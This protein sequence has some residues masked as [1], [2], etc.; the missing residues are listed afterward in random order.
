M[1]TSFQPLLKFLCFHLLALMLS[2]TLSAAEPPKHLSLALDGR[3][4]NDGKQVEFSW[5]KARGS[6]VGRISIQRRVLGQS[7]KQSWKDHASVRGFA[8]IYQDKGIQ[9]GVAYEYR[10]FRPSK[11]Q[12]ETGYWATGLNLPAKESRGVAI[13]VVDETVAAD[14]GPR[15]D[16][17]MLDLVGDGWKVVRHDTPRGIDKDPVA[18]L[19]AAR[20]LRGWIQERYNLAFYLPHALILVGRVPVVKSGL[21]QPDG[22]TARPLETDLFYAEMN[23]LWHDDGKGVLRHNTI[24]GNHIEMQV[25]RIDFSGMADAFGDEVS[26]L[27]RYFDKNHHW[28]HGRLGDLRQAY[29]GHRHLF[30]ENNALLNIVGPGNFFT[31]G[32]HDVG[33]QQPWLFGVDFG[34]SGSKDYASKTPIKAVF[35]INFGSG[36]LD[37]SRRNNSM[38]A[39]QAQQWYVLTT[40]WGARPAWQLHPMA[41]GKSIGYSHLRTVNNGALS[42]GG[43]ESLEYTPTGEY[44]WVN[45]IWVNL[46]G[47][48]TLRP[49]PLQPV[50]NLQAESRDGSVH[51]EWTGADS[52]ADTRY[53][54]YRAEQ[55]FGPYR[56]LN[57]VELHDG[58]RYVDNDPIPDTWY[59]VRAHSLKKVH[60][61]SLYRYSQGSFTT[62]EN[63]PPEAIDQSISTPTGQVIKIHP[64]AADLNSDDNLTIALIRGS[65]GG[66]L[67]Q[68]KGEW[69]FIPEVG[70][71]GRVTIPFSVFD[72]IAS[73]EGLI[74]I[75]VLQP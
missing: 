7:G 34:K 74:T 11:K 53:R 75:E 48:P 60:A 55:R 23:A 33:T 50:R 19:R 43:I 35:T 59:M 32:H 71:T 5:P 49:F 65:D 6:K 66:H 68:T 36:K 42:Q 38:K 20:K 61:G 12:A 45:P 72:G 21:A 67:V 24:P 56:A 64:S 58:N 51:L 46:L 10:F 16:R 26:L 52:E 22:H 13:V 63:W 47:D 62:H 27:K 18:N 39:M 9:P 1:R 54:I 15:L 4:S 31:G 2:T 3:I 28:R 8:R 40:G 37:F 41:L 69:S 25:G 57:P 44:P 30:V 17:F 14:L 29:G 73:D 70:F